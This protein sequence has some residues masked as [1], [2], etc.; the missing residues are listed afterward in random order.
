MTKAAAARTAAAASKVP[1]VTAWFWLVKILTTGMGET[2]SDFLAHTVGPVPAV[3]AAGLLLAGALA[4]QLRL[5]RCAAGVYWAVVVLVSVFGTMVADVA[6][7]ALGVP[8]AVSAGAL[9]VALAG[10]FLL[11]HRVEGSL[12]IDRVTG[13]RREAFYWSAVLLTF[14]L[15]T[16]VG[17]LTAATLDVGY[18]LSG[19]GF[20]ALIAVPAVAARARW[21]GPVAGFWWAY[22]LTRPLGASFADWMGVSRARGGL[23]LGTGPVS[24]A[25]AVLIT[26]VLALSAVTARS[27][28]RA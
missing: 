28:R 4:L 6:H 21:V 25:L 10:L 17:D 9:A 13:L 20:T 18:L 7:V 16:A 26:A 3:A 22:V 27:S 24:L 1:P 19:L 5:R 11:W 2:L 15:G 14:A 23:D 8:Y 12:A